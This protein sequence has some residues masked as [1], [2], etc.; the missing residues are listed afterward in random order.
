MLLFRLLQSTRIKYEHLLCWGVDFLT[1][2]HFFSS[3][4]NGMVV[5]LFDLIEMKLD[6]LK[7]N[8]G[9]SIYGLFEA[10]LEK[11]YPC[12]VKLNFLSDDHF[13]IPGSIFQSFNSWLLNPS[14]TNYC[15][16]LICSF[17]F[18]SF[19]YAQMYSCVYIHI[20]TYICIVTCLWI[21]RSMCTSS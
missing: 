8:T 14:F 20:Y 13:L 11:N 9:H 4:W 15:F 5:C 16:F 12:I 21:L 3:L 19:S 2:N 18:S 6:E 1:L 7:P 17:L 10:T